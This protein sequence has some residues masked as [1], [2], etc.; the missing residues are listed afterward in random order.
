MSEGLFQYSFY[1]ITTGCVEYRLKII[2]YCEK[3]W[4]PTV[5]LMGF[6]TFCVYVM[7]VD[8]NM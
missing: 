2:L 5:I 6:E 3:L 7:H 1:V 8:G 4:D